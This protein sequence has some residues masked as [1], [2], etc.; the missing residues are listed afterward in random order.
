MSSTKNVY[1]H[2]CNKKGSYETLGFNGLFCVMTSEKCPSIVFYSIHVGVTSGSFFRVLKIRKQLCMGSSGGH[3]IGLQ[4][5]NLKE[6]STIQHLLV[7]GHTDL[8]TAPTFSNL[9][10][11]SAKLIH[12][13]KK[14]KTQRTLDQQRKS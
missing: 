1:E 9:C 7:T 8:W 6:Q 3:L 14:M 11:V 10:F 5:Y 13:G 2:K 4:P 12:D